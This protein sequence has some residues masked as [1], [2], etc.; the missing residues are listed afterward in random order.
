MTKL[1]FRMLPALCLAVAACAAVPAPDTPTGW[2]DAPQLGPD[3]YTMLDVASLG[4]TGAEMLGE[5]AGAVRAKLGSNEPPEGNYS[6][7]V[8]AYENDG[9]GAVVLTMSG[10]P[11]DAVET[12]QHVVEFDL[13]PDAQVEGRVFA[14]ATGYGVRQKCR[15]GDNPGVYT[16]QP[17]P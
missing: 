1:G 6:E 10:L 13:R 12:E 17:C 9:R 14:M 4:L 2:G 8:S 16:N 7:T 5:A 15:R 11:D 3:D